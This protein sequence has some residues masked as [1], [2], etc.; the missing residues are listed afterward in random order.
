MKKNIQFIILVCF[1][2]LIAC[3]RG[4]PVVGFDDKGQSRFFQIHEEHFS[5][6]IADLLNEIH[7][8]INNGIHN[9]IHN[10][11]NAE[12]PSIHTI[13][14]SLGAQIKN[15]TKIAPPIKFIFSDQK[16]SETP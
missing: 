11:T 14:I 12:T 13:S 8:G 6:E 7:H 10:N 1:A 2:N 3:D 16:Y 5:A 15:G 9:D 4:V